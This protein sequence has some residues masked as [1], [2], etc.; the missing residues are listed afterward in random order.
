MTSE[1]S[2]HPDITLV[3]DSIHN[4]NEPRHYMKL[5]PIAKRVRLSRGGTELASTDRALRMIEVG[6]DLYDPAIYVPLEDIR[7]D[8]AGSDTHTVCPLKGEASYFS[9]PASGDTAG[10]KDIAWTYPAP[11]DFASVL[12]GYVSFYADKVTVEEIAS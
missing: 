6:K 10:I 5:K 11:Y 9:L 4:P 1:T 12:K 3:R 7:V 8:L 2:A